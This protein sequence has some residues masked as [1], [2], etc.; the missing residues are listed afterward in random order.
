MYT[1]V[2]GL[3]TLPNEPPQKQRA[4]V[5]VNGGAK[6]KKERSLREHARR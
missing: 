5:V 6:P 3:P 4:E 2:L 1:R